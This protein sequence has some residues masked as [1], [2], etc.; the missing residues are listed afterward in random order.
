MATAKFDPAPAMWHIKSSAPFIRTR[1]NIFTK[2][3]EEAFGNRMIKLGLC[4]TNNSHSVVFSRLVNVPDL[5][6]NEKVDGASMVAFFA[7]DDENVAKLKELN[8]SV[9]VKEKEDLIPLVDGVLCVSRDGSKHLEEA[10]PFL[11]A[12]VPTFVDKPLATS[13]EDARKIA[14]TAR[15]TG[16]PLMSCSSLRFAPEITSKEARL[17]EISPLKTGTVTGMGETI[18]YG[19]HA[20]EMMSAVFGP[21]ID[22]VMNLGTE[23][24]DLATVQYADGKTVS[25][26]IIRDAK[27]DFR[28][29]AHGERGREEIAVESTLYYPETLRRVVEF[30]KTG[31]SPIDLNDTLEIITCLN[32]LVRSRETGGRIRLKDL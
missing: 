1:A 22:Y 19:V 3:S 6:P 14:A 27:V 25:L 2:V 30:V 28:V 29:I 5:P 18:F 12:G 17:K 15:R 11:E 7:Y 26:Q 10:V 24:H 16:T 21:G 23:G 32:G 13:L 20:A 4:G 8:V 9:R 31:K